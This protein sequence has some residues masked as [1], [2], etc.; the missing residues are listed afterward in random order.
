MF[1]LLVTLVWFLL[2]GLSLFGLRH[3]RAELEKQ[4]VDLRRVIER[5]EYT[6]REHGVPISVVTSQKALVQG[7]K[8]AGID[9]GDALQMR[10]DRV[11]R[12]SAVRRPPAIETDLTAP[13]R[14]GN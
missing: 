7:L 9:V 12:S 3:Q 2:V 10:E 11:G 5:R 8:N 1:K 6:L 14:R 4:H 13:V